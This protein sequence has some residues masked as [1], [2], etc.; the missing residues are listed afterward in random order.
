MSRA[1]ILHAAESA[2]LQ[3]L[4]QGHGMRVGAA[5]FVAGETLD[6]CV[7]VMRRLNEAGLHANTTLLG[8]PSS[9]PRVQ[10]P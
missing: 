5:R 6:E 2:R 1:A 3:R 7:V 9:I 10:P 8:R 4:M